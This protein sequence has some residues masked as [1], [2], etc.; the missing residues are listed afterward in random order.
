MI[1]N[2]YCKRMFKNLL[3]ICGVIIFCISVTNG[4]T[5]TT[6]RV[7][8]DDAANPLVGG[9]TGRVIL[10]ISVDK[11]AG[12]INFTNLVVNTGA[13]D[14]NT[15]FSS[16]ELWTS[17]SNFGAAA[18]TN[19]TV[20][21]NASNI[22]FAGNPTNLFSYGAG[23]VSGRTFYVVATVRTDVTAVPTIALDF[24]DANTTYSGAPTETAFSITGSTYNFEALVA[25][26]TQ[27]TDDA[28]AVGDE[29]DV[30][31]L[32]FTVNSNG[33]QSLNSTLTF[34]FNTDVTNILENFDLLVGGVNIG[35][36]ETYPL[37]GGGTVLTVT[38]FNS[39]DVTSATVFTLQADIKSGALSANDFTISLA[40]SG[41]TITPGL[42]EAFTTF[43]N[44]VDVTALEADFTQNADDAT[45][46]ADENDVTLL[47]FTVNSNGTQ[48]LN[49]TLTFTFNTDVTNILENF[50]LQVG[51]VN[52]GGAE[53]YPL[54]GG[55]TIL[56]V[57]GFNAVDVTSATIF[58][59]QAD[60]K[61]G[62]SSA[63][64]FTISLVPSGVT[65][66]PDGKEAFGTFSN[67]VDVT[68][69]EADF[70]QNADD[71]TA[72][73][74]Q[75]G[76]ELLDF[77]VNSNGT[78]TISPNLVF[79]F[80][81]D[82]TNILENWDLQVDGSD[83]S[84]LEV[85]TLNGAGTQLTISTFTGVDVTTAK[86]FQLFADIQAGATTSNDFTISLVPGGVN[87][88]PGIVEAFGTFSNSID[89]VTS[90]T[91]DI[92]LI[93]PGTPFLIPYRTKQAA[94]IDNSNLN[95]SSRLATYDLRDGAGSDPDGQGTN[96]TS[97]TISV[98]NSQYIRAISLFDDATDTE[99]PGTEQS[100]NGAVVSTITFTP[101]SPISTSDN[102]DR[103]LM[104]RATFMDVVVDN[105]Q[106]ELAIT[107]A[108]ANSS[109]S[110]FSPVGGWASTTTALGDNLIDVIATKLVFSPALP[111]SVN[112]NTNFSVFVKAFDGL[113][114]LDVDQND[115]FSLTES[116]PGNLTSFGGTT[117]TPFLSGGQFQWT[118]L[119]L[120]QSGSYPIVASD[121]LYDDAMGGDA[122]GNITIS[123]PACLV[124][125]PSDPVLCYGNT[126]SAEILGN[127]VIT[128]TDP[129]GFS[130]S[131]GS[132]TFSLALPSGFVFDQS[133]TA[134]L[135]LSGSDINT[136]SVYSYPSANV[137]QFSFNLT[138][139]SSNNN[140]IT[141]GGLKVQ[142]PHP[143][144]VSPGGT[145]SLLITR[146]GGSATIAGVSPG[147]TLGTISALQ[148]NPSVDFYVTATVG[149][150][151][152]T[153]TSFNV[154]SPPVNLI[155]SGTPAGTFSGSGVTPGP[156]R[157][158]PNTLAQGIYDITYLQ[159]S[160]S[161]C[162]S[163]AIKPFTVFDSGIGNLDPSY[164]NNEAP[165]PSFIVS[166][167][168][169]DDIF[170][171]GWSLDHYTYYDPFV[172]HFNLTNL[173]VPASA[174]IGAIYTNN[175][176]TFTVVQTIIAGGGTILLCSGTGAP[177][178]GT[179][180]LIL[181]TGTGDAIINYSGYYKGDFRPIT[182]PTNSQF[183]PALPA[184]QAIYNYFSNQIPIGF[185]VCNDGSV[186]C[187]GVSNY[188][189]F[190]TYQW[191]I[192]NPAPSVSFS[193]AGD[194]KNFCMG[195][196]SVDL[197]GVPQ[198]T[199]DPNV[200]YFRIGGVPDSRLT[201][202]GTS[203]KVWKFT[204]GPTGSP[205]PLVGPFNLTYSYLDPATGCRGT[206]SPITITVNEVVPD[207][208]FSSNICAGDPVT[209]TNNTSVLP[210]TATILTAGW[211]FGDQVVVP[212][213]PYASAISAG[214]VERTTGTY[215]NPSHLYQNNGTFQIFA[216]FQT[217]DG[218]VYNTPSQP[219]NINAL[220]VA[221][222]TWTNA[223]QGSPTNFS[224]TQNLPDLQIQSWDWDYSIN[225]NLT[226]A[227]EGGNA[228]KTT[229]YDYLTTGKDT[230]RL[231]VTTIN[232][233]RD[234]VYKPVFIVPTYSAITETN[235]YAND[236]TTADGWIAGGR[237]SSWELGTPAGST[238]IGDASATG[239][240]FAWDTELT[241]PNNTNESSWVLSGCFD[242][243]GSTKPVMSLDVW[244]D[245]PAGIDGAVLQVNISGNIEELVSPSDPDGDWITVGQVDQGINWYDDQGIVN[246]PGNQTSTSAGWTGK[247]PSWRKAI[248][249]LDPLIGQSNVLIRVAFASSN[250]RGDGFAFDNV[251]VG[252]RS[253]VVLLENFTNS[254][255]T[256]P[257]GLHNTVNYT[258]LGTIGE[259]V[260]IQ[261]HTAFPATDPI[262]DLNQ[263]MHNA[264]TAF[265]GI[266]E[267]PTIRI[268]GNY[269]SGNI[270]QWRDDLYDEQVLTPSAIKLAVS[271]IKDGEV[272]KINTTIEN[273]TTED[274]SVSGIN[275]FTSIVEK[276]VADPALL[277]S[278][279]NGQFEY[280][281]KQ[282]LPSPAGISLTGEILAGSTY[283]VPEI[284]W[285]NPNGDAIVVFVQSI[286][287]N[288]KSVHQAFL[289]DVAPL[290]DPVTGTENPNY[291]ERINL[292][293]NPAD[294]ALNIKLPTAATKITRVQMIDTYGRALYESSF[295]IG[296]QSKTINTQGLNAGVY[297]VQIGTPEGGVA[298]RKVMV[299]H[300]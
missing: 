92:I 17:A 276:I 67:D 8:A 115:Q 108:V 38:G 33:T 251:F 140:S 103:N 105:A 206:S 116:G 84:G 216:T 250:P 156:F 74:N 241:G 72:F 269:N 167:T 13:T 7:S 176:Q 233:C 222:F 180:S 131:S 227:I 225:D 185:A 142:H 197:I 293:P 245:V 172:Y 239:V 243:S 132:Y 102:N 257:T 151:D 134:G 174:T 221:N 194:K 266:T 259:V 195:D 181:S 236:F 196:A 91:S 5:L 25:D 27:N 235:S 223:C 268:D 224:A 220:P 163:V 36:A 64:D 248:F 19:A 113:N 29:N 71:A 14:P 55:G 18:N 212:A 117:L 26:F 240:G 249:K 4:Q 100:I 22:T 48:S 294:E 122:T 217:S 139:T 49:S 119:R 247:Y 275:V 210:P 85:Y 283:N 111:P 289:L 191:V 56:T 135:S 211:D 15:V 173:P 65:L 35:G 50:D 77:T 45:G 51:G 133:I 203:P 44:D 136:P 209:I 267:S 186:P 120:S 287:G 144:T 274:I 279:G 234:T 230:V 53:T 20:T 232:N 184:Y 123:S 6:T 118:D 93:P 58:T 272:V 114:N 28:T 69:L 82:V 273:T 219:V 3:A 298:R 193:I 255:A 271:A 246:N 244:S 97:M 290:P 260:K 288:K 37:T 109:G 39:V 96:M 162:Q 265:Y 262:N 141:I 177:L 30:T 47:D 256:P 112:V 299:V 75:N 286:G 238:F 73:S 10:G 292:F 202:V 11:T 110:G 296:E 52:V 80:N 237:N 261:Y 125:Q 226:T 242:F 149:N 155:G 127:I 159:T 121:D 158:N 146:L 179:S 88:A 59:L 68:G 148:N 83:I 157:F 2:F 263:Q 278:S 178:S 78:Q 192:V 12:A 300:Q 137:V 147:A 94:T 63:N 41:V 164:C 101:S 89:I 62:A 126:T 54:S 228:F 280:V 143:G 297:I 57:T 34:T 187:N 9:S 284:T 31:L 76:I 253:R 170:G 90:Q 168:F 70:T 215:Q 95:L 1:N 46:M 208:D 16:V 86:N 99:I 190:S 79:T 43:T 270:I 205:S 277:G 281:A 169:I 207:I 150:I 104:V 138:G 81:V 214:T 42:P 153:T 152:S 291:A 165:S 61:I 166:Q 32:D 160:A 258:N 154:S 182:A 175:G 231:V 161:G 106:I 188:G 200:D 87:I 295:G 171:A 129:A 124:T 204:P 199:D 254:N 21:L 285:E 24:T 198:N 264:R 145:G 229:S 98:T 252:E 66:T 23:A 213:G 60:I 282:M 128:E 201:H 183:D 40:S 130:G 107:G 218:C 189:T